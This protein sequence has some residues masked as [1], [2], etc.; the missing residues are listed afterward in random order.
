MALTLQDFGKGTLPDHF[1][2]KNIIYKLLRLVHYRCNWFK[3]AVYLT[4]IILET[5]VIGY[6][7]LYF[8]SEGG[9]DDAVH[10]DVIQV[11]FHYVSQSEHS[12]GP[13]EQQI[14]T[15][16]RQ[17][18]QQLCPQTSRR[19]CSSDETQR[20]PSRT[21]VR[22]PTAQLYSL[23][24]IIVIIIINVVSCHRPFLPGTSLEP[25]VI[26]TARASSFTLQYFPYYV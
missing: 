1:Y 10:L 21:E 11:T 6:Y 24:D 7:F 26:P 5:S 19:Y 13:R 15:R 14:I 20:N 8:M 16:R 3:W 4:N 17:R 9:E 22:C 12:F 25:A 23:T 18:A 2:T